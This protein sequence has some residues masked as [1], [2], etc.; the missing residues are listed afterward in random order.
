MKRINLRLD[1]AIPISRAAYRK[2]SSAAGHVFST[3]L[4][5][6]R[7]ISSTDKTVYLLF[8]DMSKTLDTIQRNRLTEDLKKVLNQGKLDLVRILLHVKIPTKFGN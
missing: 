4:M 3:K 7:T 2:S 5:I 8:L 6:E 1:S